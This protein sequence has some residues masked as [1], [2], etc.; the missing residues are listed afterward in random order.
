IVTDPSAPRSVQS[1]ER[2]IRHRNRRRVQASIVQSAQTLPDR[3]EMPSPYEVQALLHCLA[4]DFIKK[5]LKNINSAQHDELRVSILLR[6]YTGRKLDSLRKLLVF[7]NM[8]DY[9]AAH[10][11]F[12]AV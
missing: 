12:L 11:A 7:Q 4:N 9:K 3:V 6:L 1:D 8:D 10:R 2:L 5:R